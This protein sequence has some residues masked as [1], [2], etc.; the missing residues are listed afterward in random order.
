MGEKTR[1]FIKIL[2]G[3]Y[4]A[5]IIVAV[6]IKFNGSFYNLIDRRNSIKLSREMGAWNINLIPFNSIIPYW[7][8]GSSFYALKN[9]LGNILVFIPLGFF[10]RI[11]YK[12]KILQAIIIS[13]MGILS[14]ELFQLIT[15]L[16]YFD[17]DD[18]ILNMIGCML[19]YGMLYW[20]SKSCLCKNTQ[21]KN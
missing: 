15:M 17:I 13:F 14:I 12:K 5:I 18:I 11:K 21:L 10:M 6:V 3:I 1:T 20:F 9:I 4:F 19:G 8:R 16:G 7:R 2:F